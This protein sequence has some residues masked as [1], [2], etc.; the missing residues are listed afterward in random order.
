LGARKWL[1]RRYGSDPVVLMYHRFSEQPAYGR[2]HLSE[3]EA[4]LRFLASHVNVISL[5]E[6]TRGLRE[7]VRWP[8]PTV[9]ITIDDGYHDMFDIAFPVLRRYRFPATLFVTTSFI[10]GGM[11]Y[12]PDKLR[13]LLREAAGRGS[14]LR[15]RDGVGPLR[16]ET[17]ADRELAWG[18]LADHALA[19]TGG[20]ATD[21]YIEKLA[22]EAGISLP[23]AAPAEFRALT[24]EQV[25]EMSA[26]GVEVAAHG[27]RHERMTTLT[28]DE[29]QAELLQSKQIIEA[30]IQREV[31]SFAYPYGGVDDQDARVRGAVAG[32]GYEVGCV[33]YFDAD[34]YRDRYAMRRFGVGPGRWDFIKTAEGL[35]RANSQRRARAARVAR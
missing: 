10:D 21:A 4:Q 30:R 23:E 33:S 15:T 17:G 5:R 22:T 8:H 28:D 11:W 18:R 6:L 14:S 2:V 13:W 12:W 25:C 32:A 24:W 26:S 29:V 16:I 9:A 20:A 31:R 27:V 35:K 3:F 1:A 34:L 7:G 19:A